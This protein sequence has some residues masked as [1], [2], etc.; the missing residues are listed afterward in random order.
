[1][2]AHSIEAI[3]HELRELNIAISASEGWAKSYLAQPAY[4]KQ[5]LSIEADMERAFNTYLHQL[6]GRA[7]S[8]VDWSKYHVDIV[9]VHAAEAKSL[10]AYDVNVLVNGEQLSDNEETQLN[11]TIREIYINGVAL[12]F[13]AERARVGTKALTVT[14]TV[15]SPAYTALQESYEQHIQQLSEW[16]DKTTS[17]EIVQSIQESIALGENQQLAMK[18]LQTHLDDLA[19]ARAEKIARTEMVRAYSIGQQS[20]AMKAGAVTKTWEALPGA[21]EGSSQT[22]CLD[23]DGVTVDISDSFPSGD[24]YPPAHPF[25]RCDTNNNYPNGVTDDFAD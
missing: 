11:S 9:A 3:E 23:N 20:F 14:Q 17:G 5:L 6:A 19:D 7:Y 21:D 2:S 22:P 16:L 15:Q 24:E 13:A 25:C 18:R 8:Y 10:D 1:M 12:G 4:F